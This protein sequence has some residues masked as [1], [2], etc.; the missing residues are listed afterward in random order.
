MDKYQRNKNF[1]VRLTLK[2][3]S[4]YVTP[5]KQNATNK[6]QKGIYGLFCSRKRN[7]KTSPGRLNSNKTGAYG[8]GFGRGLIHAIQKVLPKQGDIGRSSFDD[9]LNYKLS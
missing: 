7:K 5:N 8:E 3:R 6:I 2:S 1:I 9:A 4:E